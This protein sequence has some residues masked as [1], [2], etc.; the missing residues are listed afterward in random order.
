VTAIEQSVNTLAHF[1]I[2]AATRAVTVKM[3]GYTEVVRVLR[4]PFTQQ[5]AVVLFGGLTKDRPY[6]G[7]TMVSAFNGGI[8]ALVRTLAIELA[9]HRGQRP[10]SRSGGQQSQVA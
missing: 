4:S 9:P 8:T 2:E 6:P 5:A 10:P 3:V 1:N 7:S